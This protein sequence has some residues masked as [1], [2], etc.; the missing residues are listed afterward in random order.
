MNDTGTTRA[1]LGGTFDLL[2]PGHV[3]LFHWAKERFDV[4]VVALNSDAFVRRYKGNWP[5]QSFCERREMVAACRWVDEVVL[6]LGEDSRPAILAAKATHIVNGSDWDRARLITQMG[7][8]ERWLE[9]NC[10]D[11]VLSTL[12]RQ[13][14]TTELKQRIRTP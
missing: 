8:T 13:F 6:N 12:P 14:S 9:M 1:Y 5:A 11:I 4:V 10:I 3:R 7:L 2:H